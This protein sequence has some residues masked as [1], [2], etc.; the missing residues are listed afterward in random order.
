MRGRCWIFFLHFAFSRTHLQGQGDFG[1]RGGWAPV[2]PEGTKKQKKCGKRLMEWGDT[3][4]DTFATQRR[5]DLWISIRPARAGPARSGKRCPNRRSRSTRP[6][7]SSRPESFRRPMPGLSTVSDYSRFQLLAMAPAPGDLLR[8]SDLAK[9]AKVQ[10]KFDD[11]YC[12]GTTPGCST[13]P[14]AARPLRCASTSTATP[15]APARVH[16][17]AQRG[18]RPAPAEP[19]EAA[20]RGGHVR[21]RRHGAPGAWAT[22]GGSRSAS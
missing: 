2:L 6:P 5:R 17:G 11:G 18:P 21:R 4:Q 13:R 7:R 3:K 22:R 16:P 10:A 19:A 15:V 1:I 12:T 8:L 14:A 9:G 20:A